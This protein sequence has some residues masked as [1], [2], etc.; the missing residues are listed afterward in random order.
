MNYKLFS[1]DECEKIQEFLWR[2][3]KNCA[4]LFLILMNIMDSDSFIVGGVRFLLN[5]TRSHLKLNQ[6]KIFN[7]IA[8]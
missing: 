1:I 3:A 7:K 6:G 8:V 5:K 4:T 2:I